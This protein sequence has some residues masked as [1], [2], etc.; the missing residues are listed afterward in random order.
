M[1]YQVLESKYGPGTTNVGFLA[2][3]PP[4]AR[5]D[6]YVAAVRCVDVA[7]HYVSCHR[8]EYLYDVERHDA[9]IV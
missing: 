6:E 2:G 3:I 8:R 5:G 4:E 7:G 1:L 9:L